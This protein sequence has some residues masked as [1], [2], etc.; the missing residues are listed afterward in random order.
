MNISIYFDPANLGKRRAS[1]SNIIEKQAG[2][3]KCQTLPER[4]FLIGRWIVDYKLDCLPQMK[5]KRNPTA[6]KKG[7]RVTSR[8]YCR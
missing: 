4:L 6:T 3:R 7:Q 1:N 5:H 2:K 8:I